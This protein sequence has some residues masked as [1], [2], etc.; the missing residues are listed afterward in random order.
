[1]DD[2]IE[3][4]FENR[5]QIERDS[6]YLIHVFGEGYSIFDEKGLEMNT[7]ADENEFNRLIKKFCWRHFL[8]KK[9]EEKFGCQVNFGRDNLLFINY[10]C[11]EGVYWNLPKN[12]EDVE[13]YYDYISKKYLIEAGELNGGTTEIEKLPGRTR[14]T[15][16]ISRKSCYGPL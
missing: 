13:R 5:I 3:L 12:D 8:M 16:K 2:S 6:G 7:F 14:S 15:K 1:M 11:V 9:L 10:N 4:N